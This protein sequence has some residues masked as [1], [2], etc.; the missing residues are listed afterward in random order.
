MSD[1]PTVFNGRYELHRRLARGGMSDVYLARDLLLDRPVAVKVLF[2]EFAKDENFVERFRRE[3]KAAANL[4]HPNVV[5][6]Y[7]W[8]E[9][10]ETYFIVM[11]YVEGR[12]LAD[13][14]RTDGSVEPR[15]AAEISSEIA[16]ALSFAHRNGVVHRDIKP[17]NVLVSPLGQVKVADFG[18]AQAATATTHLT[19]AGSVMGT[20]T[21]FSP[22]QAQGKAVDPR[23][24]LY[25][26]GCVLFEMLC[27]TPPFT[28]ETP[29]A[30][31]YKHVQEPAPSPAATASV[32]AALEAVT[33]KLLAK[34]P[35][36][37]Y[38]SADDLR[39]D[40]QRFLDGQKVA[41]VAAAPVAPT[42]VVPPPTGAPYAPPE[43][44]EPDE[45]PE[46]LPFHPLELGSAVSLAIL[47]FELEGCTSDW[48]FDPDDLR[49]TR[50]QLHKAGQPRPRPRREMPPP[51]PRRPPP[52]ASRWWWPF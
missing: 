6:I 45:D 12:S 19:Q 52:R 32:P 38:A 17:G 39:S 26:L 13:I 25:S 51:P 43:D 3:A 9:Q 21:Y 31:A 29:V 1:A 34:D 49:A 42:T 4:N 15:R 18:I 37:R 24:D 20:A 16:A 44:E 23:S 5:A 36:D 22:E 30:I 50:F 33:L 7:D 41:A 35:A 2:P 46:A 40:L 14:I 8:G 47:G 48:R 27:G 10:D 28:G 11:E